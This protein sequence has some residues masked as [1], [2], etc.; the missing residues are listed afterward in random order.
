MVKE[1]GMSGKM[2]LMSYERPRNPFLTGDNW[3]STEKEYSEKIAADIDEGRLEWA[4]R[5]GADA[6]I[7]AGN[8]EV[9]LEVRK[10]AARGVDVAVEDVLGLLLPD[11]AQDRLASAVGVVGLVRDPVKGG[12]A[13][14]HVDVRKAVELFGDGHVIPLIGARALE[15]RNALEPADQPVPVLD[16]LQTDVLDAGREGLSRIMVALDCEDRLSEQLEDFLEDL[17][18]DVP[19]RQN[20]IDR[21]GHPVREVGV[22]VIGEDQNLARKPDHVDPLPE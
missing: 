6:L 21:S 2:G 3:T 11:V 15:G 16:E 1:Y 4:R 19:A 20:E 8:A 18:I 10:H 14:E 12:V 17:E 7:D 22:G 13:Y 5:L 9:G